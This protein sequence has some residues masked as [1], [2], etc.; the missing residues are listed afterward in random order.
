MKCSRIHR[1]I[2][3][4]SKSNNFLPGK[5]HHNP[6]NN[7]ADWPHNITNSQF[8]SLDFVINRLFMNLFK[9]NNINIV[10]YCQ[11]CFG[12]ETPSELWV[13]R[14]NKLKQKKQNVIILLSL[15]LVANS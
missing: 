9:T 6:F 10:K 2:P 15:D 5:F 8:G 1:R 12:F 3:S 13:K 7:P 11:Y 4:P 14:A